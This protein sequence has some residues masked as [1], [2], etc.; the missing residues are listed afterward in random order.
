MQNEA[1]QREAIQREATQCEATQREALKCKANQREA[2]SSE[3]T[4]GKLT[5]GSSRRR[6]DRRPTPG[7]CYLGP[8]ARHTTVCVSR[9]P[10]LAELPR[11]EFAGQIPRDR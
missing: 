10:K 4:Q 2:T 7:T 8:S 6:D 5:H 3:A 1:T 11:E 9:L